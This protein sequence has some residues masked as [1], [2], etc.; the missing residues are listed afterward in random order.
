MGELNLLLYSQLGRYNRQRYGGNGSKFI[1]KYG[2]HTP[3][4]IQ[5]RTKHIILLLIISTI[6]HRLLSM[7]DMRHS[8]E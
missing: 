6:K 2:K 1:G 8:Y 5:K 4:L 7:N 3:M